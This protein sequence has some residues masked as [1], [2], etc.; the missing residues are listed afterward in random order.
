MV[1]DQDAA[2]IDFDQ[3]S[4]HVLHVGVAVVHEGLDEVRNGRAHVAEVD[5]PELS[6]FR[7]CPDR[8]DDVLAHVLAPLHPRAATETDADVRAAGDFKRAHV[9]VEVAEDATR[10]ASELGHRGVVRMDSDTDAQ[11]FGHGRRLPDEVRV[12][13]PQFFLREFATVS[14]GRLEHLVAPVALGRLQAEGAGG[15]AAA[16]DFPLRAPDPVPHVRIRRV[17]NPGSPEIAQVLLVLFDLPIAAGEVQR[18]LGHVVNVRVSDVR[19]LQPGGFDALLETGECFI[20]AAP[21]RN[22]D[23]LDAN[24]PGEY[25]ILLG[26]VGSVLLLAQV[27]VE[28]LVLRVD[29]AVRVRPQVADELHRAEEHAIVDGHETDRIAGSVAAH[30]E[31]VAANAPAFGV[32][33]DLLRLGEARDDEVEGGIERHLLLV[34]RELA[35]KRVEERG[36]AA[37]VLQ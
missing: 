18:D 5:F 3:C 13:L 16:R 14:Q 31:L 17:Q 15:R 21:G 33:R 19:N 8:I 22:A 4:H 6:H 11:L 34:G 25:Q 23:I 29:H 20:S 35:G 28:A 2:K 1:G 32:L 24:L 36:R 26:E 12:V 9:A 7:E 30:V 27:E 10:D 37:A